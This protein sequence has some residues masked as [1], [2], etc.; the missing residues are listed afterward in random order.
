MATGYWDWQLPYL[1]KYGFPLDFPVGK[2][3]QL[4]QDVS[5]HTSAEKFP[6]HVDSYLKTELEHKAIYGPYNDPPYGKSTH[7]SPFIT[8]EKSD[9]NVRRV[10]IDLSWPEGHSVNQFTASNLKTDISHCLLQRLSFSTWIC[11]MFG[12]PFF[13]IDAFANI[14]QISIDIMKIIYTAAFR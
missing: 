1:I 8:R 13:D 12:D 14:N 4:Q 3:N 5:A 6:E 2:E 7:T 10:I 11:K 9:S